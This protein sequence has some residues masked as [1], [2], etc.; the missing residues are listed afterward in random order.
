MN[1][2]QRRRPTGRFVHLTLDDIAKRDLICG[3]RGCP[4]TCS[5]HE[6]PGWVWV[7][8]YVGEVTTD[9]TTIVDRD[10]RHDH[11][12]CPEHA[13][14]HDKLFRVSLEELR[15]EWPEGRPEPK[16]ILVESR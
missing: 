10:W 11:I 4:R 1:R 8:A 12:L 13:S 7:I 5:Q 9:T 3:W 6:H 16:A 14:K 15:K 2:A